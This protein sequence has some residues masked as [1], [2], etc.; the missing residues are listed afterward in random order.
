MSSARSLATVIGED[1]LSARDKLYL[2][3]GNELEHDFI[4]QGMYEPRSL[5]ETLN[6]GWKLLSILPRSELS[7]VSDKVL[8]Q[9]YTGT[10]N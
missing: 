6:M 2:Q 1:E 10:A 7:R 4:N 5:D 8:D 9:H 3:F